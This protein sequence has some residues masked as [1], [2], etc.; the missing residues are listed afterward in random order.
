MATIPLKKRKYKTPAIQEAIVEAK[1][2]YN[3]FDN[4]LPGQV[5]ERIKGNFPKKKNLELIT[6]VLGA[7][8]NGVK[9]SLAPQAPILQ[10]WRMDESELVQLGPGVAVANRIKYSSWQD[11]LPAVKEIMSA[12]ISVAEPEKL[13]R[14]GTRYINRFLIPHD[15]VSLGDFF[16]VGMAIPSTIHNLAGL[17]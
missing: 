7:S 4:T 3:S 8:D 6:L 1:F 11:F 2:S 12:Y 14:L 10:A 5:F 13:I 9:P 17:T 15:S 16:N